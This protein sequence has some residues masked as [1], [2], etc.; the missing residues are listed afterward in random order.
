MRT[1]R[2]DTSRAAGRWAGG[3][4]ALAL[5]AGGAAGCSSSSP[6]KTLTF[7][8]DPTYP[9]AEFYQVQQVGTV[10]L[11]RQLA[12]ADIDIA[13]AVAK[14]LGRPVSFVDTPFDQIIAALLGGQCDAIISFMNDTSQRRRQV[15]FVDYLAAG[16]TIL[17]PKG[18]P[19]VRQVSDLYGRTVSVAE[20]T[21]EQQF[22][23]AQDAHA[24][25]GRTIKI[26]SF[27]TENDA[28]YA[29]QH[30]VADAYF[31]D[32]PIVAAAANADSSLAVGGQ[33][34][35]PIPVG[36]ALRPGDPLRAQVARAIKSMYQDGTM[37]T[38]LSK[39]GWASY[40]LTG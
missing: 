5:V 10:S 14:Q 2:R 23:Q 21:T 4:L 13:T 17:L 3:L 1:A 26:L 16:Q 9:P 32:A 28:I 30:G 19:P 40:A 6:A 24:P 15:T 22:L 37:G 20:D 25:A 11:K 29:L 27:A 8:T 12:G 38:I 7:C 34:V 18:A 36:I 39:W 35:P 33:L 31:G